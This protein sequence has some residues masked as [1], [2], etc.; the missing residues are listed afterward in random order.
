VRKGGKKR[1]GPAEGEERRS[2][3]R[4]GVKDWA[5]ARCREDAR[6]EKEEEG[7]REGGVVG[8]RERM[9]RVCKARCWL[10]RRQH[11]AGEEGGEEGTRKQ[12]GH[13]S[14]SFE[15]TIKCSSRRRGRRRCCTASCLLRPPPPPPPEPCKGAKEEDV[16]EGGRGRNC[17]APPARRMD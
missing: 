4:P 10:R 7:G 3:S 8:R 16:R 15:P 1:R 11:G 9:W 12:P 13:G 5:R 2:E 14:A 6:E 17:S